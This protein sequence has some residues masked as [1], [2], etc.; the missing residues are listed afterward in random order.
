[1]LILSVLLIVS[2]KK[3]AFVS[4][5]AGFSLSTDTLHFDT[6]F[7][8]AGSVTQFFLI[9]NNS[10]NTLR[11]E[12]ISLMGGNASPFNMNVDGLPGNR[13]SRLDIEGNDSLYVFVSVNVNP[14]TEVLPFLIRDSIQIIANGKTVFQQLEAWGQ[15]AR[16]IRNQLI[17]SNTIWDNKLPYVILGGLL[18]D[19][20][21]TLQ[22]EPG[23]RIYLN[24]DAPLII[25]GTLLAKGTKKDSIVFQGNRLDEPY[26]NF[27]GAWPGIIFRGSSQNNRLDHVYIKNAYQGLVLDRHEGN[28][29]KVILNNCVLEN[30]YENGIVAINS[31]LKANNCL[32]SN[33]GNNLSLLYGGQ[34]DFN[35]C[36]IASFSTRYITHNKPVCYAANFIR[37]NDRVF[38]APLQLNFV[39]SIV[40]GSEGVVENEIV[41]EKKNND[42]VQLD[43]DH[44]LFRGKSDPSDT[45]FTNVIRNQDPVFDSTDVENNFFDFRLRK[46]S[47]ALNKGRANVLPL[48][49]DEKPRGA[50]PDLGCYERP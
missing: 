47:P 30:I 27:P 8:T 50:Q 45:R 2:C 28:T 22:I 15:N 19:T 12:D 36:T 10:P 34:Y 32:I 9:K 31:R 23:T 43:L 21:A 7:T 5:I 38:S 49:L 6:V 46:E 39:N 37:Q 13:F 17:S 20:L 26:R 35:H 42:P 25:D 18:V 1:M 16:Y 33:C 41:V 29:P 11:I 48:D 14:D 44:V 3:E 24:A 4:G 40:W